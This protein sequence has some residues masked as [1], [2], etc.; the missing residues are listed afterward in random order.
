MAEDEAGVRNRLGTAHGPVVQAGSIEGGVHVHVGTPRSGAQPAVESRRLWSSQAKPIAEWDARHL[1]VHR[2]I[3]AGDEDTGEPPRYVVRRHDHEI[4]RA[5]RENAEGGLMVVLVGDS[6]VGKTRAAYEAV[7]GL[8]HLRSWPVVR[9]AGPRQLVEIL[10]AG[11]PAR[12]VVWLDDAHR[13]YLG[14]SRGAEI[15]EKLIETLSRDDPVLV[16]A[17]MWTSHWNL[18]TGEG[19]DEEPEWRAQARALC[20]DPHVRHVKVAGSFAEASAEEWAEFERCARHDPRLS[21]AERMSGDRMEITQLLAGGPQLVERY[22]DPGYPARA[23]ALIT[24][25]ADA[26]RVGCESPIDAETLRRAAEG[27]LDH[28]QRVADDGWFD[29]ALGEVTRREHG[30]AALTPVR[31]RPEV[32]PA[33][34]YV[35]HDYLDHRLRDV[36]AHVPPPASLW[37]AL[38][39]GATDAVDLT[40]MAAEARQRGLYR[41]AARFA[42]PAAD[43]GSTEA[44]RLLAHLFE[45]RGAEA[46][47]REWTRRADEVD[48]VSRVGGFFWMPDDPPVP[49]EGD[50]RR[51]AESGDPDAVLSL[52]DHLE[53]VGQEDEAEALLRGQA[54]A[55]HPQAMWRL[56]F[57]LERHRRDDE[58][59]DWIRRHAETG[60]SVAVSRFVERLRRRGREAE[61]EAVLRAHAEAGDPGVM[62]HLA[63]WLVNRDQVPE[64]IGWFQ[65]SARHSL[66]GVS[67]LADR[68]AQLGRSE[69]AEGPL[70]FQAKKGEVSAMK[71]LA[72]LLERLGRAEEAVAWRRRVAER[73]PRG[74]LPRPRKTEP[75]GMRDLV[76]LLERTGRAAEAGRVHA[77]GIEP[78]GA[79]ADPWPLPPPG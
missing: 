70:E 77:Y 10:D 4:R 73:A 20:R 38:A 63:E 14:T 17:D 43:A 31:E 59:F 62:W 12:G 49:D 78:G 47:A 53:E 21:L 52:A 36:R 61:A 24:A 45:L 65:A 13:R 26:R 28:R 75:S 50:L 79:T 64:A 39:A 15:A 8:A 66:L 19:R 33:D 2:S 18:M 54:E 58:A 5:L 44:M 42:V 56:V 46:E 30:I 41:L 74:G 76:D 60:D 29:E 72:G 48:G 51:R 67:L 57:L 9:P 37:T 55:G 35:V 3:T 22:Q 1:G 23:R 16:V 25:A 32:G 68:L 11:V 27:Y 40:R 6:A 69:E 7:R 34:G 71:K